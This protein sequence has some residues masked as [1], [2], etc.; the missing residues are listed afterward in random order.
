[1]QCVSGRP[2]Y[3]GHRPQDKFS[4][5][6][7]SSAR[8]GFGCEQQGIIEGLGSHIPALSHWERAGMWELLDRRLCQ[9]P[10]NVAIGEIAAASAFLLVLLSKLRE[11]VMSKLT[12]LHNWVLVQSGVIPPQNRGLD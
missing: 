4:E 1:M 12:L 2:S 6:I 8:S 11:A 5:A 3:G 10:A 7:L 9:P